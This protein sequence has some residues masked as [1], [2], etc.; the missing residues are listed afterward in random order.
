M[1]RPFELDPTELTDRLEEMVEV[2]FSDLTSEFLLMPA[3]PAYIKYE[4]FREA[5][6]TL[7]RHTRAFTEFNDTT[8]FNA[9]RENSRT[10]CV[11]RAILGMT[12]PEWAE[13]ART[14][15]SIDIPQ[16]AARTLDRKCRED[17]EYVK[18]SE[19]RFGN[20]LARNSGQDPDRPVTLQRIEALPIKSFVAKRYLFVGLGSML[21]GLSWTASHTN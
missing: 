16:N 12:P 15:T 10:L 18:R 6:E 21:P 4:Q 9:L 17:V 20:R 2:T 13:L 14:E 19:L 11:I 7:K 1:Q 8:S 5:Y 3:G